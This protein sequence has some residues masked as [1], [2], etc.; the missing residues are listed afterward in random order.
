MFNKIGIFKNK[1]SS[2]LSKSLIST[3]RGISAVVATVLIILITVAAVTIIW[4]AIVPMI[5]QQLNS[6]TGCLNADVT[7]D[8]SYSCVD[9][10]KGIA[11]VRVKKGSADVELEELEFTF[12]FE[13]NSEK[14]PKGV[15]LGKNSAKVFYFN[16]SDFSFEGSDLE[17]KVAPVLM[18]EGDKKICTALSNIKL[19]SCSLSDDVLDGEDDGGDGG[20]DDGDGGGGDGGEGGEEGFLFE[21][22]LISYF[23]FE[24][25]LGDLILEI[26]AENN[27]AE[28]VE[29]GKSGKGLEFDGVGDFVSIEDETL[30]IVGEFTL[31]AWV[32]SN[33]EWNLT[34]GIYNNIL[35]K[36]NIY[37]K[38][39]GLEV[40]EDNNDAGGIGVKLEVWSRGASFNPCSYDIQ[41]KWVVGGW[42]HVV[43]VYDGFNLMIY[44]NGK[45]KKTCVGINP[46]DTS[47]EKLYIGYSSVGSRYDKPWPGKIDE[48]SIYNRALNDTEVLEL[49]AA[50]DS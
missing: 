22:D 23:S 30:D 5:K 24:E 35:A 13:G 1:N 10:E 18:V 47:G 49:Y 16:L 38:G 45:S 15:E 17:V 6:G 50:F 28:F 2:I 4:T 26:D 40:Y 12:S 36:D 46:G 39:Y 7:I 41:S 33:R 34:K 8:N 3:K 20:D 21:E 27:G 44:L 32:S 25:D 42:Y 37:S 48:V 43:G 19:K 31:S 29:D 11:A 9:F 14:V